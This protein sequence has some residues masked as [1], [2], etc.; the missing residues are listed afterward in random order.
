MLYIYILIVYP[1]MIDGCMSSHFILV[2]RHC[3]HQP[4]G[5]SVQK[6]QRLEKQ[7]ARASS[8]TINYT[9]KVGAGVVS[10]KRR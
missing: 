5:C 2:F 1:M 8:Q 4:L 7:M 9:G 3:V 10:V 6:M